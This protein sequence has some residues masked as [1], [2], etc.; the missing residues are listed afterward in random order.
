MVSKTGWGT[1]VPY[2]QLIA[3]RIR[4]YSCPDH[5]VLVGPEP[6]QSR[7]RAGCQLFPLSCTAGTESAGGCQQWDLHKAHALKTS[8]YQNG[9]Q[10]LIATF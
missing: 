9:S 7:L 5:P 3:C 4:C 10:K 8:D 6:R 2:L 1:V